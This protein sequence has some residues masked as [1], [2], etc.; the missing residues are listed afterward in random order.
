MEKT[1]CWKK[2]NCCRRKTKKSE[3]TESVLHASSSSNQMANKSKISHCFDRLLCC[4]KTH[5]V[6]HGAMGLKHKAEDDEAMSKTCCFCFKCKRKD[7]P[8]N[9][10]NKASSKVNEDV[11]P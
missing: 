4:R 5:K 6:E 8:Q 11:Q 7:A 1:S 3:S 9:S 2:M 10:K